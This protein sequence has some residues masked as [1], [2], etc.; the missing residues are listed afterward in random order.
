MIFL[1]TESIGF[2][3]PTI[4]IQYSQDQ[5]EIILYNIF[6]NKTKDTLLLIEWLF[7]NEICGYNLVHDIFHLCRTYNVLKLLP[8][9]EIPSITSIL[10]N[11]DRQEAHEKWCLKPKGAL[12]LM[13]YGRQNILQ[14]TMKQK[15]I[16]IKRVP[17]ILAE[18]LKRLLL[19]KIELSPILFAKAK[20]KDIWEIKEIHTETNKE[21]TPEERAKNL[22]GKIKLDIDQHFVNLRL[23][24]HPSSALKDVMY[25]I[26]NKKNTI[27]FSTFALPKVKEN[28]WY[29]SSGKWFDVASDYLFHW[30]RNLIA[31]EYAKNDVQYLK[32]LYEYFNKPTCN[33]DSLLACMVG[34]LHWRGYKVDLDLTQIKFNELHN[35]LIHLNKVVNVNAPKQVLTYLHEK[36]SCIEKI[37]IQDTSEK[38]LTSLIISNTNKEL[39]ERCKRILEGRK[40]F[41]EI[42]VLQK[43]L[44]AKK[45]YI[46]FKI[47]GTKS[48]RMSGGS[49]HKSSSLN[50]QG[51]SKES[52]MR[53]ILLVNE[54]LCGGDYDQFEVSIADA[55]Y[56]D[57]ELKKILKSERSIHAIWGS[58]VYKK[59]Y[60][61]ILK[62]KNEKDG[63]YDLAKKSFFAKLY[64]AYF[65]KLAEILKTDEDNVRL[66]EKYF[67]ETF[68]EIAKKRR[69][70]LEDF[71]MI[72]QPT[73][74][75]EIFYKEPKN[76]ITSFLG[77][78]RYFDLEFNIVRELFKLSSEPTKE[79]ADIGLSFT[80]KR[81]NRTQTGLGATQSAILSCAFQL[82]AYVQRAAINHEIQSPGARITKDLQSEIYTIQPQG[83]NEYYVCPL[84]SH[85]EIMCPCKKGVEDLIEEKVKNYINKTKVLVPFLSMT[86]KRNLKNW[87]EK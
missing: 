61:E 75:G 16:V 19:A 48:D 70:T 81:N 28:S 77:Y 11:E 63:M 85:D 24:F 86:W 29:P 40:K 82:Q 27:S 45:F 49:I 26:L 35:Y 44:L 56:K 13:I 58:M 84:N 62:T 53:K 14:S 21:V 47:P 51:I 1:D 39:T 5:S 2:F 8:E 34:C 73:E 55:H 87:S 65:N 12:D 32:D 6:K 22:L 60:E 46:T 18:E 7:C 52:F 20:S 33:S 57:P 69:Q 4:L 36:C 67:D 83:I 41:S 42:N 30:D 64:C 54:N 9:N 31:L 25:Y 66:A 79:L 23:T 43:L 74:R 59:S 10:E 37:C 68:M 78:S 76:K 15:S 50:P 71:T 3:G 80:V 38:T 17:K 72:Y